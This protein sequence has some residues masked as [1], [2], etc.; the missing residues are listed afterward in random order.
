MD[1]KGEGW[2]DE[3]WKVAIFIILLL[4]LLGA[5]VVLLW[6]RGGAFISS[7]FSK[8]RLGF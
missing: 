7:F 8:M 6:E 2:L 3:P 1:K 5:V 4:I